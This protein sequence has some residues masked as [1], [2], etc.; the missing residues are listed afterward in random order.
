MK[1]VKDTVMCLVEGDMGLF[2]P[3]A[4]RLARDCKHVFYKC[5]D[6]P[7]F[8]TIDKGVIGDGFDNIT[9]VDDVWAI[10][11]QVDCFVFPDIGN[12][13]LQAELESQGKPVWGSRTGDMLEINRRHFMGKLIDLNL[14]VP[15]YQLIVGLKHLREFLKDKKDKFIKISKYRGDMETEHWKDWASS[16]VFLDELAVTFG[17]TQELVPFIVC[18]KI[19]TPN[20]FGCDTYCINGK[21]PEFMLR[22]D[23]YK[24]KALIGAVTP[25]LDLPLEIL[26]T[27]DALSPEFEKLGYANFF[28]ME[29]RDK[30]LI[31]ATCRGP[32]PALGS[33]MELF[34]N[35]SDII[36]RGSNYE[37]VETEPVVNYSCEVALSTK[38]VRKGWAVFEIPEQLKQWVKIGRC[39]QI[40]GKL[41]IPKSPMDDEDVGWLVAI[42]ETPEETIQTMLQ[43][44]KELPDGLTAATFMLPDLL[45]S[46][47]AGESDGLKFAKQSMPQPEEAVAK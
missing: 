18:D 14:P 10:K 44:A 23:E 6:R 38:T 15:P 40:D 22:A 25:R 11:N 12:A 42:G 4:Q 16:S 7:S 8:P 21:W 37:L 34:S 46:I 43:Q 35:F 39:C 2:L 41:C 1:E 27:I 28:S 19:D 13:E 20:E 47:R 5:G 17:P 9:R 45:A 26:E 36:W 31:D 30:F 32:L 24:D 3:V 29:L 33:Q